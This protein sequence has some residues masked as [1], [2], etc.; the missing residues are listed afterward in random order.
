MTLP[1]EF[2]VHCPFGQPPE[3]LDRVLLPNVLGP[4]WSIPGLQQGKEVFPSP[5]VG[6]SR[7]LK[8]QSVRVRVEM[9]NY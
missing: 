9:Q 8:G 2:K 3:K 4:Q 6:I 7:L 1:R 5:L